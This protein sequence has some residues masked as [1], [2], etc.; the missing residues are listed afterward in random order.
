M[1]KFLYTVILAAVG[2][3][4]LVGSTMI[5]T[6]PDST[7]RILYFLLLVCLAVTLSVSIPVY[8]YFFKKAPTFTNLRFLYRKGIK[9]GLYVGS[10]T[11]MFLGL[12]AFNLATTL[13]LALLAI[14]YVMIFLQFR[15]QR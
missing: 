5:N 15:G 9:W 12:R 10:L 1:P 2:L 14:F 7:G 11:A 4:V 6:R 13:N 8:L 3:W